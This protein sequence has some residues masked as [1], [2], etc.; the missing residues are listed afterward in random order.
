MPLEGATEVPQFVVVE[1]PLGPI[2]LERVVLSSTLSREPLRIG[3]GVETGLIDQEVR[4][5]NRVL[6]MALAVIALG[7]TGAAV[8]QVT[9]GLRPL[10]RVRSFLQA[11]RTGEA[12]RLPEDVPD[13]VAPLVRDLNA[14]IASNTDMVRRARVQAGNLAHGL[15]T[16]LAILMDEAHRL[17]STDQAQA[18]SVIQQQ[19]LQ[20]QR[21]VDYQMARARAAGRGTP[22][23]VTIVGPAVR[24]VLSAL[25]RLHKDRDLVLEYLGPDDLSVLCDPQDFSEM[26]GNLADNAAKW[27]RH[28]VAVHARPDGDH[29]CLRVEDDGPGIEPAAREQVFDVGV[30][31][32]EQKPGTGL[33]LAITRELASLYDG[34]VWLETSDLGGLAA[35]LRLPR[36][37]A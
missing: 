12:E 33:G 30:K 11:V 8:L 22:G 9:V 32:D 31:L 23:S 29:A 27:A 26:M 24:S 34:E 1:S 10:G 6:A 20:M 19:C 4:E 14:M 18:A 7:L 17:A 3:I 15:K 25:A 5:L 35:C 13:E 28:R 36:V 2:R 16:P 37:A 21:Q